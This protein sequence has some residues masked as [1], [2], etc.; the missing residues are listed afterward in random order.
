M[1]SNKHEIFQ[2][3]H[4]LLS[5]QNG[6]VIPV[7]RN[8][9]QQ[10]LNVQNTPQ[11]CIFFSLIKPKVSNICKFQVERSI[12]SVSLP[13]IWFGTSAKDLYKA[14]TNSHFPVEKAICAT[15]HIF[16]RHNT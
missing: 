12:L 16:G 11:R 2:S 10:G 6:S 7:E 1:L 14:H 4:Y 8:I 5:H 3:V 15:G 9:I 13:V